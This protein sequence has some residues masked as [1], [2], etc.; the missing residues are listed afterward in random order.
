MSSTPEFAIIFTP[1]TKQHL[2]VIDKKYHSLIQQAIQAQL[3]FEPNIETANKKSLEDSIEFTKAWEIRFGPNNRFRV[4]YEINEEQF[5]VYILAIGTK[6]RN[7]LFVGG[8]EIE[9]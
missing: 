7:R 3:Q 5:E 6:Q 2:S 4:L 9:L 1:Q 8:K